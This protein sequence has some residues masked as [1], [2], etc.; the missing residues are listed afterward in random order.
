MNTFR[1]VASILLLLVSVGLFTACSRRTKNE[2]I[3]IAVFVPGVIEGSPSYEMMDAGVRKA[4]NEKKIKVKTIEGNFDQASWLTQV[5]SLASEGRYALI[6]TSNA[7]MT[8]ICAEVGK[9]FPKQEFLVLDG[10][11]LGGNNLNEVVYDHMEQAY[12]AGR[13]AGLVTISTELERANKDLKVGLIVGQEY[14]QM[15]REIRPGFEI[16]LQSVNPDID[17]E[18]RVLGNW[19]DAE[20]ARALAKGLI[21]S[22]VDIILPIT[23]G[24]GEGVVAAAKDARAYILWFDSDGTGIA[25]GTVLASSILNQDKAAEIWTKSWIEGKLEMGVSTKIGVREGYVDFPLDT[26]NLVRHVPENIRSQMAFALE[27]LK[28][29]PFRILDK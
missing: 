16:G 15:N 3:T 1:H 7:A 17:L 14:P 11:G 9:S 24:A 28:K 22:G 29:T 5:S 19:Y 6:V 26:K 2:E 23:G 10:S 20:Q 18:Y 21:D 8:E 13:F 27:E 4:A 25:P 12:L